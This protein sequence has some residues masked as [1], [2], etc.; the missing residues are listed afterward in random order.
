MRSALL[1]SFL[2]GGCN[3]ANFEMAPSGS[4][5]IILNTK[6]GEARYCAPIG[7]GDSRPGTVI[8]D[9]RSLGCGPALNIGNEGK[10]HGSDQR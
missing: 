9:P 2:L 6:S 8:D 3:Q 5:V 4:G 7:A 1:A 10:K